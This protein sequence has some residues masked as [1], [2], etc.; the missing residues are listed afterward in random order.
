MAKILVVDDTPDVVRLLRWNLIRQGHDVLVAGDGRQALGLAAAHRPDA[1]L[2]D[3]MMPELSGIDV[4]RRL[5]ADP[6]LQAIPIILLT[7]KSLDHEVIEGLDAGADDY[8]TK[9]FTKEVLA[10]RLRSA[11]RVKH[12]HDT[13]LRINEQLRA[14]TAQRQRMEQELI[15]SQRLE[16]V[17]HLAAGIA[18]EINT[19]AQYIGDDLRFL[20]R[21]FAQLQ[22]VLCRLPGLCQAA[23][24]E[25]ATKG[26]S[27]KLEQALAEA[28]VPYLAEEIP[29]AIQESLEGVTQ[30]SRI[31]RAL[32]DFARS[33][34]EQQLPVDLN[35]SIENT[36]TISR[37]AWKQVAEVVTDLDPHLPPVPCIPNLLGQAL[38]N[39][40]TNAAQAIAAAAKDGSAAKGTITVRT[41]GGP[42]GVEIRVEDTG[43]GIPEPIRSRVYDPFFTTRDVGE[44]HGL[45]LAI[46]QAIV[47]EKHGG[48]ICFETEPGRGTTFIIRLPIIAG[49][50][51]GKEEYDDAYGPVGR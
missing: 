11:L 33:G 10:A 41:R 25:T 38:L 28:D 3:V 7:A 50:R 22:K 5:K 39:L 42:E 49:N 20:C 34:G 47:V 40:L 13:M 9:P 37:N 30:I 32:G 8:V 27:A 44:G 35:Q 29:K 4:C 1:I 31:V 46:A 19:P 21:G 45:G 14:E 16:A 18:H 26:M 23:K 43:T 51:A 6:Q 12:H 36:L 17:G 48:A 2:L 15:Q 24:Q